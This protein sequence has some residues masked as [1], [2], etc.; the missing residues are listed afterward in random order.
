MKSTADLHYKEGV[1]CLIHALKKM[2]E[3]SPESD[4]N[5]NQLITEGTRQSI[6]MVTVLLQY[7]HLGR[8]NQTR[9]DNCRL[10]MSK[11]ISRCQKVYQSLG[12][13]CR[14]VSIDNKKAPFVTV[15]SP[16]GYIRY[17]CCK[18]VR[19]CQYKNLINKDLNKD[20]TWSLRCKKIKKN[21]SNVIE[22]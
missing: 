16:N 1:S 18:C 10:N 19:T 3:E 22:P 11:A 7:F 2:N 15:D 6:D 12:G 4:S 14:V 21:N 17:G 20:H 5:L 13:T 9:I 8:H